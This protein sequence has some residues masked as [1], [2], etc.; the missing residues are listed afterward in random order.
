MREIQVA[1]DAL[2][3]KYE[4]I[5]VTG[6]FNLKPKESDMIDFCQAYNMV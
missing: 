4:N 1:L 3:S 6:D 5:I 2:S